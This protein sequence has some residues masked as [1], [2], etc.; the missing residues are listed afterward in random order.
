MAAKKTIKLPGFGLGLLVGAFVTALYFK[1]K[2]DCIT[3]HIDEEKQNK[4]CPDFV[5]GEVHQ[6][7]ESCDC[8]KE[9]S[10]HDDGYDTYNDCF[11][12]YCCP[13]ESC[14]DCSVSCPTESCDNCSVK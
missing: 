10:K 3:I 1:K 5:E 13:T 8:K 6:K 9:S 14:D 7:P 4:E 12:M 11:G 2:Y